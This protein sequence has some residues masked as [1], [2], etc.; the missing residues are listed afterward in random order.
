[1]GQKF[2]V[3]APPQEK[4]VSWVEIVSPATLPAGATFQATAS[5]YGDRVL[6]VTVPEGG[7]VMGQKFMAPIEGEHK[8]NIPHGQ[9]KDGLFD[10]C[11]YG[12]FHPHFW[13]SYCCFGVVLAQVMVRMKL[14]Y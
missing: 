3:P 8:M 9:W 14:D 1:M 12:I 7:V 10:C 2:M 13:S 11:R 4:P 6:T 5:K